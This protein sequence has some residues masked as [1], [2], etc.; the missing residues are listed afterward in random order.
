MD[1]REALKGLGFSMGYLVATPTVISLLQSCKTDVV[2]WKPSFLTIDEGVVLRNLVDLILPKTEASPGALDVNVPEFIDV[3]ANKALDEQKQKEYKSGIEAIMDAL[4][5]SEKKPASTL[6]TADYDTLLATYLKA[7]KE[8]QEKFSDKEQNVLNALYGL[9]GTSVWAYRTSQKIG[10][11]VL[12]Y[13]PIPGVQLG[14]ISVE[15]ATGG[16]RWSL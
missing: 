13:D 11:E 12:A 16:K 10:E 14:C 3:Y 8:E 9:R 7:S 2:S 6:K 4:Q 1:R 15:E 5:V